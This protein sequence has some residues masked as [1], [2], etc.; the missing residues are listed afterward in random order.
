MGGRAD[1][2]R[3][4]ENVCDGTLRHVGSMRGAAGTQRARCGPFLE[5]RELV[6][7]GES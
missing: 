2:D 7:L 3:Q 4:M 1:L 6:T 5:E